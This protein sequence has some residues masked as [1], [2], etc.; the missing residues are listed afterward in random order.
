MALLGEIAAAAA[1][2]PYAELVQ[3]EILAPLGMTH[4]R[5]YLPKDLHGTAMALGYGPLNR[6]GKRVLEPAFETAGITP[7]AGFTSNVPDL[8]AFAAW[9]FRL[10]KNG[11]EEV[12]KASTLREMQ[13]VHWIDPDWKNSRGLGFEVKRLDDDIVVG[14]DGRCPGYSSTLA[15]LPGHALGVIVLANMN[16]RGEYEVARS[17]MKMLRPALE[18]AGMDQAGAADAAPD[19]SGYEGLYHG[20]SRVSEIAIVQQGRRLLVAELPSNDVTEGLMRLEQE[21]GDT[22]RRIRDHRDGLGETWTFLRNDNDEV[23]GVLYH[24]V[25]LTK[26]P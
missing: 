8:A 24:G 4:T 12:L 25:H 17:I 20:L 10:L 26:V 21:T 3:E 1:G 9:Q 7:A 14:H 2:R 13:R 15:L 5:P 22:F 19:F 23:T 16:D 11:G 6:E 18:S